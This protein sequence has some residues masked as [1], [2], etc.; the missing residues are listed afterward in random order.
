MRVTVDETLTAI[1]R[2]QLLTFQ[3]G[4]QVRGDIAA[5]LLR[6]G[7]AVSPADDEAHALLEP[8]VVDDSAESED[9]STGD[10]LEDGPEGGELDISASTIDQ[11][12]AWV[13]DNPE[14]A[15][16]AH[17]AEEARGDKARTRLLAKLAEIGLN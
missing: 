14:R 7:A 3:Q 13:G 5:Y 12:L 15:L 8:P 17:A 6:S 9:D 1:H 4:E 2:C 10:D 16:T 11:V